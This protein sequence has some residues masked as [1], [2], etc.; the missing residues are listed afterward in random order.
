MKF[1]ANYIFDFFLPRICPG[2]DAKISDPN[3]PVCTDCLNSIQ[4][5]DKDRINFEFKK[6]F[7]SS[8]VVKDFYSKYIFETDKTLQNIIH[9]L[10]Y[11]RQFK[12]GFFL[13]QVLGEEILSKNW[14]I[15]LIVPVPIHHLRKAE[16]GYN[17]T[18]YIAK[19]L[20]SSLKIPNSTKL[21]KRTRHTE[22]QTKLNMNERA[23]NVSNAFKVK[24]SKKIKDKNI[25]IVD[26]ICT[27]GATILECGIV[28]YKAGAGSIY[29]SS[30][31]IAA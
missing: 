5:A 6:N 3:K 22:S 9:A 2:C 21:L 12:L 31:A 20:S 17:Q 18:D 10:K 23:Q 11:N 28:L 16:R 14:G 15:D 4:V 26:D 29:A 25:L 27:T 30:I 24:N 7:G 8:K 13:G 1:N 19:G